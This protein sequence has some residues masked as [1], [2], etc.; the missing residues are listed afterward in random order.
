MRAGLPA[1]RWGARR[2][3]PAR[4]PPRGAADAAARKARLRP[5]IGPGVGTGPRCRVRPPRPHEQA[6]FDPSAPP[7]DHAPGLAALAASAGR[8]L[9]GA[10]TRLGRPTR[11]P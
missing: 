6:R 4:L 5:A 3:E 8:E 1:G 7:D 11:L 10:D 2:G 9:A